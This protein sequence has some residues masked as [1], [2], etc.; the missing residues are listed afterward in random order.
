VT[1]PEKVTCDLSPGNHIKVTGPKGTLEQD[2][3]RDVTLTLADGELRVTRPSDKPEHRAMHGLVRSLVA[4]M[5]TGVTQGYEKTLQIEG[6]GYRVALQGKALNLTLG[7]SH[8]VSVQPPDGIDFAVEGTQTI[9]VAG[10]DKQL[11]GQVA[12]NL[13]ALR[14]PEPYK[15]K[16]VRYADERIRRKVGKSGSK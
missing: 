7:F 6:V 14:K 5:V 9:K 16:G 13:R 4:N 15:G 11:V 8:P 1:I 2:L 12:A 3:P 10:I